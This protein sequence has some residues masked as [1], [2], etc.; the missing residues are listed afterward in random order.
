MIDLEKYVKAILYAYPFLGTV[1]KEY[2]QHIENMAVLSYRSNKSGERLIEAIADEIV[3]KDKLLRLREKTD[4]ALRTLSAAERTLIAIRYFGL[5]KKMK[6]LGREKRG[7][8]QPWSESRY[9][10]M[11][12]RLVKRVGEQ[13][14]LQGVTASAFNEEY[15]DMEL[16]ERIFAYMSRREENLMSVR[17]KRWLRME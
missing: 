5:E 3:T 16:F 4:A 14:A 7:G 15:A 13:L 11:Q 12:A 17:E 9:F 1:E 8:Y 10:R 2:G 6:S